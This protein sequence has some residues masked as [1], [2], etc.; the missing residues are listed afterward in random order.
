MRAGEQRCNGS[1]AS[2]GWRWWSPLVPC[3]TNARVIALTL[4]FFYDMTRQCNPED[5]LYD[6]GGLFVF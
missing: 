3:K 6:L 2:Y 4:L 5:F 1:W